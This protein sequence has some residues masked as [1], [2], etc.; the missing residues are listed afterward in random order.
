MIGLGTYEF[1]DFNTVKNTPEEYFMNSYKDKVCEL[2]QV[3][4][5]TKR[6][7]TIFDTKY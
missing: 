6:L 3:C 7:N 4:T 1:R 5:S 2:E